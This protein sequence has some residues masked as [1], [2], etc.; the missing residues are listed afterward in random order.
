MSLSEKMVLLGVLDLDNNRNTEHEQDDEDEDDVPVVFTEEGNNDTNDEDHHKNSN[1][2]SEVEFI[3]LQNFTSVISLQL[4]KV[5]DC[6]LE[7]TE[8][9]LVGLEHG[10]F[11]SSVKILRLEHWLELV[12]S[13]VHLV[14][15]DTLFIAFCVILRL[16][17]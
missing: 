12:V 11:E 5:V 17:S 8:E 7:L 15:W 16:T 9:N 14:E 6:V 13:D 3:K 1:Q 2:P 10:I 4:R